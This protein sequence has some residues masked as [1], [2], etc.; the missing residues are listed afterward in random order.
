MSRRRGGGRGQTSGCG[1]ICYS[2]LSSLPH[3]DS[4]MF[5]AGLSIRAGSIDWGQALPEPSTAEAS[6][7]SSPLLQ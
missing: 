6:C 7:A 5:Q 1:F 2:D 3:L 4:W